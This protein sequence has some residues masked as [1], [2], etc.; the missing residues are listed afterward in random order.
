MILQIMLLNS[1]KRILLITK[2]NIKD[3]TTNPR[4]RHNVSHRHLRITL[5]HRHLRSRTQN[6]LTQLT[7]N[8]TLTMLT[9]T[10][11][12]P[13]RSRRLRRPSTRHSRPRPPI[14]RRPP[15]T[16]TPRRTTPQKSNPR[17]PTS[18]HNIRL[19]PRQQ[20]ISQR[21]QNIM[22]NPTQTPRHHLTNPTHQRQ[23]RD[24]Q[25]RSTRRR[26][27][28]KPL[29]RPRNLNHLMTTT[30][31]QLR[32]PTK[33]LKQHPP[34]HL[35]LSLKRP[36]Q[37]TQRRTRHSP[38]LPPTRR[39]L[40]LLQN[41]LHHAVIARQKTIL[42][43]GELVIKRHAP[44]PSPSNHLRHTRS[45][46]P[47][48]LHN[49]R[50]RPKQ[51]LTLTQLTHRTRHAIP[52]FGRTPARR[53]SLLRRRPWHLK[54]QPSIFT[55]PARAL[56]RTSTQARPAGAR[57]TR[58]AIRASPRERDRRV[59]FRAPGCDRPRVGPALGATHAGVAD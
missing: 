16:R 27:S 15:L 21:R 52:P 38:T 2:M 10:T 32:T 7:I 45:R 11:R 4:T 3:I 28:Q 44:H 55:I 17:K 53:L 14:P 39:T 42:L 41:P 25:P 22:F 8:K 24:L 19:H 5:Q 49:P 13:L 40:N 59:D 9:P 34:P 23:R 20:I 58:S 37:T 54:P 36:K 26:T 6:P 35:R 50:H 48:P 1:K 30:S 47:F 56:T 33:R 43:I 12:Q 29:K 18:R 51:P 31:P 57:R 46:I